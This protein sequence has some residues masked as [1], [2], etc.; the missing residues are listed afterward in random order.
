MRWQRTRVTLLQA[1]VFATD[2]TLAAH[3]RSRVIEDIARKAS[4]FGGRVLEVSASS[5][6]VAFGLDLVEDAAQHAAHAGF[7]MQRA[8]GASASQRPDVR[9]AL[10]TEE[11]L[12]WTSRGPC[13]VGCGWATTR[14]ADTRWD[15]GHLTG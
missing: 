10:H 2:A 7:A 4:A 15:S 13:R 11:M 14:S 5:V 8:L 6:K 12:R 9:I 1:D 3:E